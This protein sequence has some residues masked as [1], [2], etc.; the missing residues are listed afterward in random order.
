MHSRANFDTPS[1]LVILF[2]FCVLNF[3][4]SELL[5]RHF[6][7]VFILATPLGNQICVQKFGSSPSGLLMLGV[8]E[9]STSKWLPYKAKL[10]AQVLKRFRGPENV[11]K[12]LISPVSPLFSV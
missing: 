5:D 2:D 7:L 3:S 4:V 12:V 1:F 8:A 9:K 6:P 11:T 10:V